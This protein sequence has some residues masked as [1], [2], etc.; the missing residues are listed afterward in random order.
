MSV[1]VSVPRLSRSVFVLNLFIYYAPLVAF[2]FQILYTKSL[3][4]AAV[5]QF[6]GSPIFITF[7]LTS[8]AV[9]LV[10]YCVCIRRIRQYDGSSASLKKANETA[11]LYPKLSM[12]L[13][14]LLNLLFSA[15]GLLFMGVSVPVFTAIIL[16]SFGSVCLFSLFCYIKFLQLFEDYLQFLPLEKQYCSMPLIIRSS[17]VA[18]FS[19]VG[20]LSVAIAPLFVPRAESVSTLYLAVRMSLPLG[21]IGVV[22]AILDFFTQMQGTSRR[23]KEITVIAERVAVGDYS[24]EMMKVRSR[25]EFGLLVTNL[26]YFLRNTQSLIRDIKTG[27]DISQRAAET[28]SDNIKESDSRVQQVVNSVSTVKVEMINQAA[29]VEQTQATINQISGTIESLNT[30]I[31]S[32]VASVAQASAAIEQMVANIRSVTDILAKNTK[33]VDDLDTA[34]LEGQKTV[35]GA[36]NVSRRIYE[37]SEGLI[38][39][40]SIIKHIA[41]QTNMLAM[42]A[43]IE[44]AHAGEAGKGFAVVADEIRKLAEDSSAQSLMITSRLKDLGASIGAVSANTQDVQKQFLMIFEL[45]QSVKNQEEVIMSAMKEQNTGSSQVLGAMKTIKEITQSVKDGASLMLQG[46]REVAVEM[47]KLAEVT[48]IIN[49]SMGTMASDTG[50]ITQALG[51]VT[52]SAAQN[53][54]VVNNLNEKVD[55]F[56]L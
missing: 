44:A 16:Q 25:D 50:F 39:A 12:Y 1:Q 35:E 5:R 20:V 51:L 23:L 31:E 7:L 52:D 53:S 6:F 33:S 4:G 43:A 8:I 37:E 11:Q 54:G 15:A 17:L 34:A 9:P 42:N 47:K 48:E 30:S 13:P 24:M 41:E 32:Q 21:F 19:S 22:V 27:V 36:V 45:A 49:T 56:K 18:F 38:E 10:L 14:I 26:N 46:S 55:K 3:S 28:L 29:G 2:V 40:S